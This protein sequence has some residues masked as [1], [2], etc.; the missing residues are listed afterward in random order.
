MTLEEKAAQMALVEKNSI[1]PGNAGYAGVGGVLSGA[2]AK[3]EDNTPEGW[4]DMVA[5]YMEESRS[6]R[7][8]IPLL[9]GL[10]AVHGHGN[11]PGATLFPHSIG[12]GAAN[13]PE[14]TR[15]VAEATAE[16]VRASGVFWSFSPNLDMPQDI[17]WGRVYEGFS[18]DAQVTADLGAA[19]IRGLQGEGNTPAMLATAKHYLGT[20]G[21]QWGTAV[22]PDYRID[23]GTTQASEEVIREFYLPPFRAA[24]EQGA[25][26]VMVGLNTIDGKKMS[27]NK[28]LITD[29]LKGE[30]GFRG[31]V[32]SDWYGV[33]EIGGGEYA[34]TVAAINA[35]VDMVMLPF[36][37]KPFV[38]NVVAAVQNG[39]ISEAR[40]NDA[41]RRIL[42]AKFVVGLFDNSAPSNLDVIG[43]DARRALAREAVAR[44]LVLLKNENVLP[45][46]RSPTLRRIAV[47]GSAADNTGRQSGAWTI[48]W[49]GID[50]NAIPG[51]TSI[52][53]GIRSAAGPEMEILYDAAG[54][55]DLPEDSADIGI[56]VV[57]EGP[58]AEGV[59][60]N[61]YPSL[62]AEDLQ[63]IEGLRKVSG[64]VVVVIVS[65]R[66]LFIQKE[67]PKWDALVAAWLPG[68][69]GAGVAD[70]LFGKRSFS[71]TL[72]L[73]WPASIRQL[74]FTPSGR[75]ADG[76][77]PLF[78]R[79][80]GLR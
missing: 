39:D 23:Q 68:S 27:A 47:A 46:F 10:D 7:L 62:S 30:L 33:Y 79:G 64:E 80:F 15:R 26:S 65:G 5:R 40:V 42:Y 29:V 36:E 18:S 21:M 1:T 28:H 35:G 49:Q 13:D 34:A 71:G 44:S 75:T 57:G 55:F 69:E 17:R 6:S 53:A 52:L 59:G 77:M 66:P 54:D 3:P 20:G 8:G 74:P 70:V 37:Y 45:L 22:N 78:P 16:E 12:L 60:D 19:Y 14:L 76:A 38:Q 31:F 2:G 61:P 9:Y 11:V 43:A 72:P 25:L 56:A 41:V 67:L 4:R 48:E 73:P 24:V 63:A 51:A 50:G 32:V 58:Y